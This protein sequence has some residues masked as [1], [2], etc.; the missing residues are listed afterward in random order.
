LLELGAANGEQDQTYLITLFV[1]GS[2]LILVEA[3]GEA[4]TFRQR[5]D[6]V[7]TAIKGIRM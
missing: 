7:I 3:S 6:T 1:H 5:R 4:D 2:R